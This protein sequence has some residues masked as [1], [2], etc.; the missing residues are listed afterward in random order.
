MVDGGLDVPYWF[1]CGQ[2]RPVTYGGLDLIRC[3][4]CMG[5]LDGVTDDVRN[6]RLLAEACDGT[7]VCT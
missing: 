6:C 5:A 2:C 4:F 7:V 1:Q 3:I